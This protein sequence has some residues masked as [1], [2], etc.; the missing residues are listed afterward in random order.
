MSEV[1]SVGAAA[2]TKARLCLYRD[3]RGERLRDS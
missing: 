1:D 2:L 3:P